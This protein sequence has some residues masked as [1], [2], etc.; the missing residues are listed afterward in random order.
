ML[1]NFFKRKKAPKDNAKD[2]LRL[3]LIHDRTE[4]SPEILVAMREEILGVISR[5]VEV[6][7]EELEIKMTQ[8]EGESDEY[9]S[10]A[11]VANIPIKSIKKR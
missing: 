10:P 4:L 3:I 1:F 5:Y 8:V 2:R 11:L 9:N 6:D 7:Q